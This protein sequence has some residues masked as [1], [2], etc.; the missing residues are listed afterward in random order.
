[1][2]NYFTLIVAF[3]VAGF[4]YPLQA[5]VSLGLRGGVSY[6]KLNLQDQVLDNNSI[7][8]PAISL[9]VEIRLSHLTS[10]QPEINFH[11][12]AGTLERSL[13]SL[14]STG[15]SANT[16]QSCKYEVDYIQAP[17]LFKISPS[18]KKVAFNAFWGPAIGV[19]IKGS[20][21]STLVSTF[22]GETWVD[23]YERKLSIG[24]EQ[25]EI[26]KVQY[27]FIVGGGVDYKIGRSKLVIDIR[28]QVSLDH[29]AT[30]VGDGKIAHQG[31]TL[32][33]GYMMNLGR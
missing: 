10:L 3:L 12:Q 22:E 21:S 26:R 29:V 24:D 2:K 28:H 8:T 27:S 31:T 19:A 32:S 15:I 18:A 17:I 13:S 14:S 16:A 6:G 7:A 30:L 33:F 25:S 4:A 1:M 5:Q 11:R 23:S 9:P 20:E